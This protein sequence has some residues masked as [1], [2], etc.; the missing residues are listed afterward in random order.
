MVGRGRSKLVTTAIED[1]TEYCGADAREEPPRPFESELYPK[2]LRRSAARP[3]Q[4]KTEAHR[5][6]VDA[7]LVPTIR[8]AEQLRSA[9]KIAAKSGSH[10]VTLH[11]DSFPSRLAS[12]L[13]ELDRGSFTALALRSGARHSLLDLSAD[14]PQTLH[15]PS[16]LDISRKRNLGLLIGRACGW[17]RMLL[18]DDDIQW[19]NV[20]KLRAASSVLRG[21]KYP[22]VGIQVTN[23]YPDASVIGHARR[24]VNY[25]YKPFISGGSL[26]INPQRLNGFFPAVY[27]EDWLCILDHLRLG[28][29]AVRGH[30]GQGLYEPFADP[31][32]A[33]TE[34]FGDILASGL[35]WLV[36][37][38]MDN[39]AAKAEHVNTGIGEQPDYWRKA[40]RLEF[41]KE[42]LDQRA[43]LLDDLVVLLELRSKHEMAR[44]LASVRAAQRRR[45]ELSA[46]E[47]VS[48]VSA[49]AR[50]LAEWRGRTSSLPK[51]DSVEKALTELGL[52]HTVRLFEGKRAEV[53]AKLAQR[54]RGARQVGMR[55]RG[56][57][58]DSL[59]ETAPEKSHARGRSFIGRPHLSRELGHGWRLRLNRL[60]NGRGAG[61]G[62]HRP[63]AVGDQG[64]HHDGGTAA[65]QEEPAGLTGPD[66][67]GLERAV[68]VG[69]QD[70]ADDRHAQGRADLAAG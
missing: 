45:N 5:P 16:A 25:D 15:S 63:P 70:R 50:N 9:V 23:K 54:T 34:E 52:L 4:D 6:A 12:V 10:L 32:R 33:R 56:V 48:F 29:V 41:W 69:S 47:F 21:E 35:L 53:R 61:R 14:L 59:D 3:E 66:E 37:A 49:W 7:I 27:H 36:H 20:D 19:L 46:T 8:S 51:A 39:A 62:P 22:V 38:A 43:K 42:V 60:I 11:T 2:L 57:F 67:P 58:R 55:A 28:E 17:T 40:M 26:L 1:N 65:G 68:Q 31:D 30:V 18:L 44:P 64:E 13:G 24:M